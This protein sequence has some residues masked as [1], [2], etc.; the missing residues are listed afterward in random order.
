MD[1]PKVRV[2][3]VGPPEV[4]KT[5]IISQFA[6]H[7]F[8]ESYFTSIS[9]EETTITTVVDDKKICFNLIDTPG[10]KMLISNIS[11]VIER[12]C[13]CGFVYSAM[14]SESYKV[15]Q[16]LFES[17]RKLKVAPYTMVMIANKCSEK[18]VVSEL[19]GREYAMANNLGYVECDASNLLSVCKV[20]A[21]IFRWYQEKITT[22]IVV[23]DQCH[24][25]CII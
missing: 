6:K 12:S 24:C 20:F 11:G 19:E 5:M 8:V 4:G 16:H 22:T 13:I 14:S 15:A 1:I 3:L 9:V 10:H 2:V 23:N 7:K 25:C 18:R 17:I 21:F